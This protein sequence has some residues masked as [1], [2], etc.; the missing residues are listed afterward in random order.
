ME[1]GHC[2]NAAISSEVIRNVL[3]IT[4]PLGWITERVLHKKK[5]LVCIGRLC[6]VDLNGKRM[7]A[8]LRSS[9]PVYH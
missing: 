6:F 1:N 4:F 3:G 5:S 9:R 8:P 7:E 2:G